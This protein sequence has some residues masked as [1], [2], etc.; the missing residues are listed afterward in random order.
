MI[1]RDVTEDDLPTLFEHQ[2]E[3]EA[4]RMAQFPGREREAFMVHWRDRI[5]ANPANT[6]K[7]IEVGGVVVGNITSWD[8]EGMRLVG[9]WLGSAHWG[10]GLASAALADFVAHHERTR[11]LHAFVAVQNIG[12]IR[13][14]EKAGF[15]PVGAP[16]TGSDGVT[17]LLMQLESSPPA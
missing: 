16:T 15:R 2:R 6:K 13:V 5:L 12:S 17:E 3:P 7:V 4:Q 1:L 11:P 14:L 9:Y 10:R 8:G